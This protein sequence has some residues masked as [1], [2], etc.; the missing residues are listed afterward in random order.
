MANSSAEQAAE[1][2][3]EGVGSGPVQA[4]TPLA[5]QWTTM[6]LLWLC[7]ASLIGYSLGRGSEGKPN[8]AA[9]SPD[10]YAPDR[11]MPPSD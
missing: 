4:R 5:K 2:S 10:N 9:D 6:D 1:S 8:S 3:T 7:I 11:S